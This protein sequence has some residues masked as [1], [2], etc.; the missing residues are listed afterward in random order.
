MSLTPLQRL[1]NASADGKT[2]KRDVLQG[3]AGLADMCY[4]I[5]EMLVLGG[6]AR[7]CCVLGKSKRCF[8]VCVERYGL[9]VCVCEVLKNDCM[10]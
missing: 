2:W 7:R 6:V 4:G 10:R 3:V 9:I 5:L 1:C 8:C